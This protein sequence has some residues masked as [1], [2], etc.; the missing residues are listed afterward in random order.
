SLDIT[1]EEGIKE[2]TTLCANE[3]TMSDGVVINEIPTPRESVKRL[4][5]ALKVRVPKALL[6]RRIEVTTK[7]K[8]TSHREIE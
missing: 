3:I 6:H 7:G 1:V 2:L 8:F 5:E 4:L